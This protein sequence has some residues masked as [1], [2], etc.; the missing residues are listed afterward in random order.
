MPMTRTIWIMLAAVWMPVLAPAPTLQAADTARPGQAPAERPP[1]RRPANAPKERR[2]A[3]ARGGE[4]RAR[5]DRHRF[6]PTATVAAP[7]ATTPAPT[8][9]TAAE[10]APPAVTVLAAAPRTREFRLQY[11][12][13]PYTE[14]VRR[15]C[16]DLQQAHPGRHPDRGHPDV[17]RQP[18]V[19]V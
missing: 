8:A 16:P 2:A 10:A 7:T 18:A 14:V 9:A 11:E 5:S 1:P 13:T 4:G 12:G 6:A 3:P 15:F 17:H 19:Y